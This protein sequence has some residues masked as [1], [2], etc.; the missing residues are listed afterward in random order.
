MR[1]GVCTWTFGHRALAEIADRVARLGFEGVELFGDLGLDPQETRR[2]LADRGLMVLSL[3]PENVDLAHPDPDVR[4]R[5]LDYYLRLLDFAAALEAPL[6]S[7]HGAVGRIR[8]LD[9]LEAEWH[10]FAEGVGRIAERAQELG[11]QVAVELLNR[12]ESHL[13]NTAA[14]GLRLL[15]QVAAPNMG[16]LLDAYHMNIEEPDLPG[17][18]RMAGE[19]LFLFHVADSNRQG[20]GRGHTDFAALFRAL[21]EIDYRGDVVLECVAPGPDPFTAE[22]GPETLQW[23][24]TYLAESLDMLRGLGK[25]S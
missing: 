21:R 23:L 20:V 24:E 1:Y 8:P 10:W 17:A 18:I 12:Y 11:L 2:L 9:S 3:T 4:A 15:E 6:I 5:A 19:R 16:L 13:L 14:E 25:Q 22:K 7:C